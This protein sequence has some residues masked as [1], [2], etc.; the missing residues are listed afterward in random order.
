MTGS[1][2]ILVV[3]CNSSHDVSE[4]IDFSAQLSASPRG[5]AA[6]GERDAG[7]QAAG[8]SSACDTDDPAR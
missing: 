3:N 8:R 5:P 6:Q 2:H 4:P 1:P 7:W